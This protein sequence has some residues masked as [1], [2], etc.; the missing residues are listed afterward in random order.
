MLFYIIIGIVGLLVIGWILSTRKTKRIIEKYYG[1]GIKKISG[2]ERYTTKLAGVSNYQDAVNRVSKG[3]LLIMAREPEN[4]YDQ[5][6]IAVRT[7]GDELVGYIPSD[8]A[9]GL[10]TTM[11]NG[12]K[13]FATV[14]EIIGKNKKTQGVVVN[15][16]YMDR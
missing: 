2:E 10:S 6:A 8:F 14:K 1:E 7:A 5:N 15:I 12:Q 16:Y 11:D 3:E 9:A 4:P 13:M